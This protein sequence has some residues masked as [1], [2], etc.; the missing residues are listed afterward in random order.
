[1]RAVVQRV[2]SAHVLSIEN[3]EANETGRIGRGYLVLLGVRTEDTEDDARWLADK[4]A[5]LRVFEDADGKL[6]LALR[7]VGGSVLVVPNFTLY[8]DCRKGR[9]P[10]FA[11]AAP[12][13]LAQAL[14]ERFGELLAARL[15]P[16]A[17]GKFGTEMQ[18]M[19]ANDGPVT[20]V[21][22]TPPRDR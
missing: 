4:I 2:S 21:I 20:L 13:P 10:S 16:V 12:G 9:R 14:Y 7:E 15:I 22:D 8:G 5:G 17:Y 1:M 6:N 11:D 18:V 19:L 3:G